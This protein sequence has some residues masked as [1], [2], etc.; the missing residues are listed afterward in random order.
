MLGCS[1]LGLFFT[2]VEVSCY[3]ILYYCIKDH[4]KTMSRIILTPPVAHKRDRVNAIGLS[5]QLAV[6][7][8]EIWYIIL[9]GLLHPLINFELFRE[10]APFIKCLEFGMIPLVQIHTSNPIKSFMSKS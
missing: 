1:S 2:A 7:L 4:N 10:V 5:G 8:M 3:I 9:I 6:W